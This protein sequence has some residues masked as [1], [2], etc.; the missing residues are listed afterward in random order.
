LRRGHPRLIVNLVVRGLERPLG[1][2]APVDA[3][4]P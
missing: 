4:H 3:T 1:S 2:L